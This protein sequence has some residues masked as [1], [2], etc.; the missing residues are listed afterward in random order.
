VLLIIRN[1]EKNIVYRVWE[2]ILK[3][4][5]WKN[6]KSSRTLRRGPLIVPRVRMRALVELARE[7]EQKMQKTS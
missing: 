2:N 5:N 7:R 4:T 6:S 1:A 3:Q